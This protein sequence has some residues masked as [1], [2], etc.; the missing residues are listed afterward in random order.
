MMND[1][2]RNA[3]GDV[4]GKRRIGVALN[5]VLAWCV[6]ASLADEPDGS[7]PTA[8]TAHKAGGMDPALVSLAQ[9]PTPPAVAVKVTE[10]RANPH[11][12]YA[13]APLTAVKRDDSYD[14]YHFIGELAGVGATTE[15]VK[16]GGSLDQP[17]QTVLLKKSK[18]GFIDMQGFTGAVWIQSMS[19]FP[20]DE[21]LGVCH[22]EW[23]FVKDGKAQGRVGL[24]YSKNNGDS[25]TYLGH[26]VSTYNDWFGYNECISGGPHI[27]KDGWLYLYFNESADMGPTWKQLPLSVAR[28][29]LDDVLTNARNGKVTPFKKFNNGR[30]A[31]D[32]IGGHSTPIFRPGKESNDVGIGWHMT[33]NKY[34]KQYVFAY[35]AGTDT[36]LTFSRDGLAWSEPSTIFKGRKKFAYYVSI[37]SNGEFP[38]ETDRSFNV[39]TMDM[40][41]TSNYSIER[42]EVTLTAEPERTSAR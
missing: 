13:D 1:T 2:M 18:H 27:V 37:V 7:R 20:N 17:A 39:Y 34:L 25:W 36:K 10:L 3:K 9:P 15:M 8:A 6:A 42:V 31:D 22:V 30:W 29:R 33:Y 23:V 38:Q 4:R 5:V 19:K 40:E 32:G 41:N 24:A 26:V 35:C 21:L 11:F 28:A 14:W 16:M 12:K